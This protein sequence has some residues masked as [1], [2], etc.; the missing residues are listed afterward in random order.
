MFLTATYAEDRLEIEALLDDAFGAD[1]KSRATYRLRD[2]NARIE[3]LSF[4]VRD[5]DGHL[6]GSIE[7]W[8]ISLRDK[9]GERTPALLLGPIAVAVQ[10]RNKGV[11]KLLIRHGITAAHALGYDLI[12]LVGDPEYYHRFGFSNR[13]TQ[14]WHMAGQT[15]QHRLLA[16]CTETHKLFGKKSDI[17]S[18]R[19]LA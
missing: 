9:V 8:P 7:F 17:V 2:G 1:R 15:E 12:I 14:N 19:V 11:G 18:T 13:N 4:L 5:G 6:C 16:L 10:C 3:D